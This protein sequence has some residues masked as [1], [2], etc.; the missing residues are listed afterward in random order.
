MMKRTR[1]H[2][3]GETSARATTIGV[4]AIIDRIVEIEVRRSHVDEGVVVLDRA[5]A[6]D[7]TLADI[8]IF[9]EGTLGRA[10]ECP[11]CCY[12]KTCR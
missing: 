2:H 4:A 6:G 11:L 1:L 3:N 7:L 8:G 9:R 5:G 10:G 12:N